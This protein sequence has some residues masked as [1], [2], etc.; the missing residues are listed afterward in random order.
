MQPDAQALGR[1]SRTSAC[2]AIQVD[3]RSETMSLTADDGDHERQPQGA[4]T[5]ERLWSAAHAEPDGQRVLQWPRVDALS[6]ERGTV[7]ARPLHRVVV[8]DGQQQVEFFR[9]QRVV[10]VQRVAEQREGLGGRPPSHDHFRP[11]MRYQVEGRETLKYPDRVRGAEHGHRAGQADALGARGRRGQD[12][13]GRGVEELPAV[14]LAD[15]EHIEPGLIGDLDP[16]QHQFHGSNG[17]NGVIADA[18]ETIDADFHLSTH[19]C[20]PS[21]GIVGSLIRSRPG[22]VGG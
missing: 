20:F 4:G 12:H 16:L 10:V 1:V 14:M 11:A 15:T 19:P 21:L 9:E 8:A 3:Q 22:G 5:H 18:R 7:F 2:F 6:N 17:R 13:G